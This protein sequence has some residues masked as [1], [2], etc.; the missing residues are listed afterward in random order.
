LLLLAAALVVGIA[1]GAWIANLA[2]LPV[3][4]SAGAVIGA[5]AGLAL[6]YVVVHDF[7]AHAPP[8]RA[9]RH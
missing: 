6:G 4:V 1:S 8:M 5:V 9:R 2:A 3:A 7:H